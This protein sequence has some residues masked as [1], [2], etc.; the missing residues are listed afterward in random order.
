MLYFIC[1]SMKKLK[2]LL[3][4]FLIIILIPLSINFYVIFKNIKIIYNSIDINENYD[5]ALILGCSVLRNNTPSKM[6][7]DRLNKGIELYTNKKVSQILISGDH[8]D[9][10]S[11]V[12]VMY[13]YLIFNGVSESDILIDYKGYSTS[14]SLINY[15]DIYKEKS[16]IIVTQNYHLYRA[17]YIASE[18][19]LNATGV[20]AKKE[21]YNGFIF[22]EIREILA[23]NKDFFKFLFI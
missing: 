13:K 21:N 11:E 15:E 1:D 18:L 20:Y 5:I 4:I 8:S 12:E 10:Y 6:L 3:I 7:K 19:D 14:D 23:R 2:I 9:S 22:R 16:V 17:L